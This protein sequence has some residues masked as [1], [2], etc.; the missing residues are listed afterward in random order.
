MDVVGVGLVGVGVVAVGMGVVAV[1]VG[2]VVVGACPHDANSN[3][4]ATSRLIM[5]QATLRIF[6]HSPP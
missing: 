4:A 1:G 2:V 3:T 6:L 5:G